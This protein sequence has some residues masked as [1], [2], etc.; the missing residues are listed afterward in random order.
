MHG[1]AGRLVDRH[2][3]LVLE[4]QRELARRR[5]RCAAS[6]PTRAEI[7]TGGSRTT[8]PAATRVSAAARPLF[9]RT[10]PVR[11]IR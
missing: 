8:S 9:T 2:Q 1:H 3:V 5:R 6:P 10:S 4:Q 11:M 7:R